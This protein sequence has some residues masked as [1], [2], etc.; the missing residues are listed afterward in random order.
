MNLLKL[1]KLTIESHGWAKITKYSVNENKIIIEFS[2]LWECEIQ[3]GKA[4]YGSHLLRGIITALTERLLGTKVS[5]YEDK[6]ITKG[7]NLCR[8][9]II[10]GKK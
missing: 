8:F 4:A 9:L 6:C 10:L 2:R 1:C 3:L 7:D 5:V